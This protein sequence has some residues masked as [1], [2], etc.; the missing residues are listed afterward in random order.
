MRP[1]CAEF[2]VR[3]PR[4]WYE[5]RTAPGGTLSRPL[6]QAFQTPLCA[7]RKQRGLSLRNSPRKWF[8]AWAT[9]PSQSRYASRG[10]RLRVQAYFPYSLLHSGFV[11]YTRPPQYSMSPT[12]N[13]CGTPTLTCL[14]ARPDMPRQQRSSRHDRPDHLALPRTRKARRGGLGGPCTLPHDSISGAGICFLE[15]VMAQTKI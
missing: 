11:T 7:F 4:V 6:K 5:T 2:R 12:A 8:L 10:A 9:L 15:T 3:A 13:V 1:N 14:M